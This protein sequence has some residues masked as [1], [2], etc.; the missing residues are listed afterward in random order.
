[1]KSG[2][3]WNLKRVD[4]ET[5]QAV[6][7][8][9]RR[10]GMTVGEW[11][12]Q[13]LAPE[14]EGYAEPEDAP[15]RQARP[16]DLAATIGQLKDRLDQIER[17][18]RQAPVERRQ[19]SV[20]EMV[21]DLAREIEN[22]D[23]RARSSIE[24]LHTRA[25]V[26][27]VRPGNDADRIGDAI[28][29][30]DRQI[31]GM[32]ERIAASPAPAQS[33]PLRLDDIRSKLNTLLAAG[34]KP[35]D[36]SDRRGPEPAAAVDAALKALENR[37]DEAKAKFESREASAATSEQIARL[38]A[39][40]ADIGGRLA[41]TDA[42]PQPTRRDAALA[43][44][45]REISAHQ[46]TIDD[47]AET[48]AMRRDQK[49]LSAAMAALRTELAALGEQVNDIGRLGAEE[50]GAFFDLT[51]RIDA[52]A[53]E[54]P[55]D[56][57]L[58]SALRDDLE[59]L[60]ATIESGAR[61]A[62]LGKLSARND[63]MAARIDA[64]LAGTPNRQQ[65][66]ALGEEVAALR[67]AFEADD[68]P[69]AIA[70]LE[71]RLTEI[72]GALDAVLAA[73][74]ASAEPSPVLEQLEERL[75]EIS[76]RVESLRDFGD[77][78]AV[79]NS[80]EAARRQI[81]TRL[82]DLVSRLGGIFATMPRQ[83]AT[84]DALHER[85]EAVVERIDGLGMTEIEPSRA[86]DA[87][88]AEI[89]A[90][91]AEI[92]ER[93]AAA[94]NTNHLEA[95]VRELAAHLES[96]AT[97]SPDDRALIALERQVERL[98]GEIAEARPRVAAVAEVEANLARLQSLLADTTRESIVGARAEA[99]QA[100]TQLSEMV[101]EYE[102]DADVV[103]G[104]MRDLDELK[105][106][107]GTSDAKTRT[108]L[109][110]VGKTLAEVVDRLSRLESGATG[111]SGSVASEPIAAVATISSA[112]APV[113]TE[114][115][116]ARAG[117][118]PTPENPIDRR[119]DFIAAA[120]RAARAAAA[121]VA[122][123]QPLTKP[124]AAASET[125]QLPET[126]REAKPGAF[127]RISQ[128]IRNRKR[129]LLLAAA[130]I[131]IA[132]GAMQI[133]GKL[134]TTPEEATVLSAAEPTPAPAPASTSGQFRNVMAE[135]TVPAAV[136]TIPRATE[137]AMVAPAA[138]PDSAIA[139]AEPEAFDNRFAISPNLPGSGGFGA[140]PENEGAE[141]RVASANENT[142]A[143]ALTASTG[144]EPPPVAAYASGLDPRLG[145]DKLLSAADEGDPV[146]AFEVARRYAEGTA[147]SKDLAKA[148]Q[149]YRRAAE[150]GVAVAQ[151]RLAS[152]YERG[153]GVARD[154]S[155]AVNWYQ[156]AADQ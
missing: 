135:A 23:E 130:A 6:I 75:R 94:A 102:I 46:R 35:G 121:R 83:A 40:L 76:G 84:L 104:L 53:A 81:E 32:S 108:G 106:A 48:I 143:E 74:Q 64:L 43:S 133:Y 150:G 34:P 118:A 38:E 148:V 68:N 22:P 72:G 56:R 77:P 103:R 101:A 155:E 27:P 125:P 19:K 33:G 21:A 117:T 20:P 13:V 123:A 88:R 12:N 122:T 9:A 113:V 25:T 145:S 109:E 132:I 1:M 136:P 91:R 39:Q 153:Q 45:I 4:E 100:V 147:V 97:S 144:T 95:Q 52:L 31:A 65:V 140:K 7:E 29:A 137:S 57:N 70:R 99:Q 127:A 51:R 42:E 119:A 92:A 139:F 10:S 24:G 47:R 89:A 60:R 58:L 128:A 44:A 54:T 62:T 69:R 134:A 126:P 115:K 41:A 110:S 87:M 8:A 26:P 129:P 149:W 78:A 15:P 50:H 59:T 111:V 107:T 73:Q 82:E 124:V 120:R 141:S 86:L 131:V 156:R 114:P 80:V 36:A 85:L 71:Q 28:R 90:L 17:S 112:S 116:G 18:I 93:P 142:D 138:R 5:R 151:Y 67:R 14:G 16:G 79:T 37:I 146:A 61:E 96:V 105:G 2:I 152:L 98:A 11:L 55:V 63:D 49:A 66:E 154:R 3:P 30:L